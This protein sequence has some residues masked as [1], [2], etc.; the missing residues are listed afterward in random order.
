MYAGPLPPAKQLEEYEKII[1]GLA[2]RLVQRM[3]KQSDHRMVLEAKVVKNDIVKSYVG[4]FFAF[5]ISMSAI[6]AGYQAIISGQNPWG[7]APIVT[8]LIGLVTVF[9]VGKKR[10]EKSLQ[11][12]KE[13]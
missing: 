10:H 4:Q 1:P 2:E 7:I 13:N 12:R 3:E 8:S 5:I 9:I 6:G 11:Q